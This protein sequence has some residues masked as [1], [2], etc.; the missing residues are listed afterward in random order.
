MAAPGSV[1]IGLVTQGLP[2]QIPEQVLS[3]MT[4]KEKD[5]GDFYLGSINK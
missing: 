3:F 2:V 5:S 4:D 1:E